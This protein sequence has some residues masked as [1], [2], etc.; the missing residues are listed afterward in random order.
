[1]SRILLLSATDLEHGDSFLFDNEIHITGIGKVNAAVETARLINTYKPEL[2]VNFG[3]C[4]AVKDIS[5]GEVLKVGKVIND[6]DVMNLTNDV[7]ITL[8]GKGDI[9]CCTTDHFYDKSKKVQSKTFHYRDDIDIVDMELYGIAKA[10]QAAS[11]FCYS[12][13]WVSDDGDID[14]WKDNAANGYE[15]FKSV[16]KDTFL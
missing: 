2:V 5:I 9:V 16:F 4:G 6:L 3:S 14:K 10:C 7:D 12:Y 13:K 1:M 11:V 15:T 8:Q